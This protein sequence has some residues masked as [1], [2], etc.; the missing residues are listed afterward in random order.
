MEFETTTRTAEA[1]ETLWRM[2]RVRILFYALAFAAIA[3]VAFRFQSAPLARL[4]VMWCLVWIVIFL[5][6]WAAII[7]VQGA[8]MADRSGAYG[9]LRWT[10]DDAGVHLAGSGSATSFG[11]DA[12]AGFA[13]TPRL[14]LLKLRGKRAYLI[15][16]KRCLSDDQ[17]RELRQFLQRRLSRS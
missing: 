5:G 3:F 17:Q 11:W 16:P 7:L 10:V 12:L 14:V 13:D 8:K 4:S 1:R 6:I 9:P 15:V 2:Y